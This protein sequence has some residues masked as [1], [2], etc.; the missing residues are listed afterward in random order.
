[1]IALMDE[2]VELAPGAQ[3]KAWKEWITGGP[4][5][6]IEDDGEPEFP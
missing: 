1:V 5:R 2:E 4:Q 6:P 3:A